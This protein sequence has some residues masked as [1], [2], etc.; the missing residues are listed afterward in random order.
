MVPFIALAFEMIT[1]LRPN[2]TV[3]AVLPGSDGAI[4]KVMTAAA[5]LQ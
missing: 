2:L 5:N 1:G 4:H 3:L